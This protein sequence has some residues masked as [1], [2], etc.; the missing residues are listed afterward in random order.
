MSIASF[1]VGLAAESLGDRPRRSTRN[2]CRSTLSGAALRKAAIAGGSRSEVTKDLSQSRQQEQDNR[3]PLRPRRRGGVVLKVV[4]W[5]PA[6]LHGA[7]Y[8][9]F[10]FPMS[11]GAPNAAPSMAVWVVRMNKR[12]VAH[13]H[14]FGWLPSPSYA[15]MG[16]FAP[17]SIL[18][19]NLSCA[20]V[21]TF[22]A[23]EFA[24]TLTAAFI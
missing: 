1:D 24:R 3:N 12:R 7:Y 5:I 9:A 16:G 19:H 6:K 13:R 23:A 22:S 2:A 4:K 11:S 17:V 18:Y 14:C 20:C 8:T 21:V 15:Q 10:F